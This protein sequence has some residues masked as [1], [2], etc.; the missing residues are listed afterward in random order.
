VSY[1]GY[2]APDIVANL[3]VDQAWG[4]AQLS[5]AL[6]HVN[7]VAG[8][9][10]GAPSTDKWGYAVQAGV[11]FNLPQLAAGDQL[12]L[13]AS[14]AKG[15]LDYVGVGTAN[16]GNVSGGYLGRFHGGLTRNDTDAWAY[17]CG[18]SGYCL[19]LSTAWSVTAGLRHFWA[20]TFRQDI[21]GSYLNV[22]PGA[23]QRLTDWTFGGLGK[24]TEWTVGT[25]LTWIP[26]SGFE[27]GLDLVYSKLKQ[28]LA[29]APA[30]APAV[31]LPVGVKLNPDTYQARL[32]FQRAF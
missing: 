16:Q 1:A 18:V 22:K 9:G 15:A 10:V 20:P 24:A 7:T 29:Q 28:D 31:L 30:P 21:Y 5:G 4:S 17:A 8:S 11:M 2:R 6:H 3:R 13:Q 26:V 12:W 25:T 23:T 27:I 14:Y 32:R 19:D